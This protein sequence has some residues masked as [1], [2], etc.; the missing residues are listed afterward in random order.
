M[1]GGAV[2]VLAVL[3][4]FRVIPLAVDLDTADK[5]GSALGPPLTVV[6]I[7]IALI[8]LRR[9]RDPDT[10]EVNRLRLHLGR[11]AELP[12]LGEV[13]AKALALRVHPAIEAGVRPAATGARHSRF[14]HRAHGGSAEPDV[15]QADLP[16]FVPRDQEPA[17]EDWL[18]RAAI[19]GGML[20]LVGDSAVGKSRLLYETARRLL[21]DFRVLA[22]SLGDGALVAE[23]ARAD[24]RLPNLVIWLDELH[25]FLEG[26]YLSAGSIP[27]TAETVQ[28]L[29]DDPT[30]VVI[31]ASCWPEHVRELRGSEEEPRRPDGAGVSTPPRRDRHPAAVDVLRRAYE[32]TVQTFSDG[33]RAAAEEIA[34]ADRR[35]EV[36]L[37]YRD[38]N[39]TEVL[40]GAPELVRRYERGTPEERAVLEA[41][42]DASRL[43]VESPLTADLLREA[44]RGY[45]NSVQPDDRWFGPALTELTRLDRST[46]LLIPVLGDNRRAVIGYRVADYVRQQ[47]GNDRRRERVLDSLW[48]ALAAYVDD[49]KDVR[50]VG[51]QA[52][53]RG[54]YGYSAQL[55]RALAAAGDSDMAV[56]LQIYEAYQ[57]ATLDDLPADLHEN[58][59]AALS[60]VGDIAALRSLADGGD[61]HALRELCRLLMRRGD[62]RALRQRPE[63]IALED[64]GELLVDRGDLDALRQVADASPGTAGDARRRLAS[65]LEARGM[66]AELGTRTAGDLWAAGTYIETL[67]TR[68]KW[69]EIRRRADRGDYAATAEM[70]TYLTMRGDIGAL[71]EIVDRDGS[72]WAPNALSRLLADRDALDDLRSRADAGD[73]WMQWRLAVLLS[74]RGWHDDLRLRADQG[75]AAAQRS[76]A[77]TLARRGGLDELR[78]R[79]TAGDGAAQEVLANALIVRGED[80]EL[81][82]LATVGH[83]FA[84]EY[85][86]NL[87]DRGEIAELEHSARA[88][89]GH[90]SEAIAAL[91]AH[92]G[93]VAGLAALAAEV[94]AARDRLELLHIE[95]LSDREF[96]DLAAQGAGAADDCR[97]RLAAAL[98][99]RG[100]LSELRRLAAHEG[101]DMSSMSYRRDQRFSDFRWSTDP[102]KSF[103][104]GALFD[105]LRA[106]GKID[107]LCRL[108]TAADVDGRVVRSRLA[109]LLVRRRDWMRLATLADEGQ[110]PA[111]AAYAEALAV[112]GDLDTLRKLAES[113]EA[114]AEELGEVLLARGDMAGLRELADTSTS[115]DTQPPIA[116]FYAAT[117]ANRQDVTELTYRAAT[118]EACARRLAWYH[119][120]RGEF[121]LLRAVADRSDAARKYYVETLLARGASSEF[122]ELIR[123]GDAEAKSQM[124]YRMEITADVAGLTRLANDDDIGAARTLARLLWCRDDVDALRRRVDDGDRAAARFLYDMLRARSEIAELRVRAE[125]DIDAA[126]RLVPLLSLRGDVDGLCRELDAGTPGADT[127]LAIL[128]GERGD[129]ELA[130]NLR[131]YGMLPGQPA[132]LS[133]IANAPVALPN[134]VA[135]VAG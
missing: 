6:G 120:A 31:L 28:A 129:H 76:Y 134:A 70:A 73:D 94:G 50:R 51:Y 65:V 30:P 98:L 36:A 37:E 63:L 79:A 92:R 133:A 106:R 100:E 91:L 81:R 10:L 69:A 24:F 132:S 38:F 55:A 135:A 113:S 34:S 95:R 68:G 122:D 85:A 9:G 124:R 46:S 71:R 4:W 93:D 7:V 29:L 39:V 121:D 66:F 35:L 64:L 84:H 58:R 111:I 20:V 18:R 45:L 12:L 109:D 43:G 128:L 82:S 54:R 27:I 96:A 114:A 56:E 86:T 101:R 123:A 75:D 131:R 47:V 90:A 77:L 33:E 5:L 16:T 21:P 125:A 61:K 44:A 42:V 52:D 26:P 88:G 99:A 2:V 13:G 117:L 115:S 108:T 3:I 8:A 107:E 87:V 116:E 102:K 104:T 103:L 1:A 89:D 19:A 126:E 23:V 15:E 53:L 74:D 105:A 49:P 97:E 14:L 130:A 60:G 17:V 78:R 22:P 32:I 48:R 72:K 80:D 112:T 25:R 119:A 127:Q 118:D 40:A 83:A 59:A 62:E 57:S 11:R 41:A 67:A 110:F